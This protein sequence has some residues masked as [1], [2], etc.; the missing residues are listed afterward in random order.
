[1]LP[2]QRLEI[3]L[4]DTGNILNRQIEAGADPVRGRGRCDGERGG[5][6]RHVAGRAGAALRHRIGRRGRGNG[7]A[8]ESAACNHR[9]F[10]HEL[11]DHGRREDVGPQRV[12]IDARPCRAPAVIARSSWRCSGRCQSSNGIPSTPVACCQLAL[13]AVWRTAA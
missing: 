6:F 10:D 13:G 9:H 12:E 11:V 2:Q 1:M 4:P 7:A 8:R 3:L 5:R